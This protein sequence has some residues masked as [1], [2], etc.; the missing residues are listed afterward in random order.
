MSKE[1]IVN[2]ISGLFRLSKNNPSKAESEKAM[3][4]A[5]KLMIKHNISC[6]D[7]DLNDEG[8]GFNLH[9]KVLFTEEGQVPD[10]KIMLIGGVALY[11]GVETM[12]QENTNGDL[13]RITFFGAENDCSL[14]SELFFCLKET[15]LN[16]LHKEDQVETSILGRSFLYGFSRV[17]KN[18]AI[19]FIRYSGKDAD[20]AKNALI[21]KDKTDKVMNAVRDKFGDKNIERE[22][23]KNTQTVNQF[24]VLAGEIIGKK[25]PFARAHVETEKE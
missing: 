1:N 20:Q 18:R 10:W 8:A 2:K 19:D 17:I 15:A 4:M 16:L 14:A 11:S 24:A 9:E 25:V 5:E 21:I 12:L 7:V 13:H 6:R 22:S 23:H 3:A